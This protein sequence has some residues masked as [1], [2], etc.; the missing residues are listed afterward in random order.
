MQSSFRSALFQP[1]N[2]AMLGV[3]ILAGVLAAWWLFP[4]G[5]VLWLIMV[6]NSARKSEE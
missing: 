2:L 5:L 6:G 3:T 4:I 1:L